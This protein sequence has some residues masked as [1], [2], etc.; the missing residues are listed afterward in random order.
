MSLRYVILSADFLKILRMIELKDKY[1]I[2][3]DIFLM[4]R[5]D[6]PAL[7][8]RLFELGCIYSGQVLPFQKMWASFTMLEIRQPLPMT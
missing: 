4:R 7:L 1:R 6:Q 2:F 5:V 3:G 8:R